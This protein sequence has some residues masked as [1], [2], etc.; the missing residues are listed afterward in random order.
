[1]FD[2]NFCFFFQIWGDSNKES[3]GLTKPDKYV[4]NN[5]T[6]DF[7]Q[8]GEQILDLNNRLTSNKD[9]VVSTNAFKHML[10]EENFDLVLNIEGGNSG[11]L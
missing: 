1:M 5:I 7:K 2:F 9:T 10:L 11:V 6:V 3:D 4:C 8:V